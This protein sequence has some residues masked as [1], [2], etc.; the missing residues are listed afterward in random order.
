MLVYMIKYIPW[1]TWYPYYSLYCLLHC[2]YHPY[3]DLLDL[4]F[5]LCSSDRAA[6]VL[7]RSKLKR[8]DSWKGS[9]SCHQSQ[10]W[11]HTYITYINTLM[12]SLV[13][14]WTWGESI[15]TLKFCMKPPPHHH[16]T[17]NNK[18]YFQASEADFT[19]PPAPVILPCNVKMGR[20]WSMLVL[21]T[22]NAFAKRSG[23]S[24]EIVCS[25]FVLWVETSMIS[26]PKG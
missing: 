11:S 22:M 12:L 23:C 17:K 13:S 7:R 21:F 2:W 14:I 16:N 9:N 5:R 15:I 18:H 26:S 3:T 25:C 1:Y 6:F 19:G 10:I 8:L 4:T 20:F 24:S